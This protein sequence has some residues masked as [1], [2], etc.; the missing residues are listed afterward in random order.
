MT[1]VL[2]DTTGIPTGPAPVTPAAVR[3][4][5]RRRRA[6]VLALLGLAVVGLFAVNVL[7]G[8]YPVTI[9]DFVRIL[10]GEQIPG[11]SFIVLENKLPRAVVATG[12]GVGFGVAGAVFQTLLRNPLASPDVIGVT[13]GASAAAV[14]ALVVL[15]GA[16]AAVPLAALA[17]AG[18]TA[19]VIQLLAAG[20][21]ATG[22]RLVLI[23]IGLAAVLNAV[24]SYLLTRSDLRTAAD[25]LVWLTGSLNHASWERVGW[26]AAAAVV[27]LPAAAAL[28][29]GLRGLE[30]G[31]DVAAATGVPVR[32]VRFALLAVAVAL[33]AVATAA[34]GPVSFIA[35]LAGPIARRLLGG[36]T[37]LAAAA[38][39]GALIVL[40]AEFVAANA[41]AD[42]ALPVG[43]VTGALGAPFLLYLLV[44]ANRGGRGG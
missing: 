39:V 23:G 3:T 18:L 1:A 35:F 19:V 43:V 26:T 11:A 41:L 44:A 31:D 5:T 14:F 15:G 6:R 25:A 9:P 34:A 2:A 42:T 36:A 29:R 38:L 7:L 8:R 24:T 13:S 40:G 22:Q 12:V 28:S 16:G 27:L 4:R 32:R 10:A 37:S 30:L 21:G 20:G 17:G 33:A